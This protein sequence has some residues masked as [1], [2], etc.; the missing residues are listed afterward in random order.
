MAGEPFR[1]VYVAFH[2]RADPPVTV[3]GQLRV[4]LSEPGAPPPRVPA[5]VVC[6]GSDGVDGRGSFHI[7]ALNAAG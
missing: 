2:T 7:A 3:A 4:P 6:H 1:T 5:V